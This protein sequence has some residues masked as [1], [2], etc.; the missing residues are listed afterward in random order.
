MKLYYFFNCSRINYLY[1]MIL[2]TH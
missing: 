1:Q 2:S